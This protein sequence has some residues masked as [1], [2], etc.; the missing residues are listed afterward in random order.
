MEKTGGSERATKDEVGR[1]VE[2]KSAEKG[3]SFFTPPIGEER[4]GP[5]TLFFFPISALTLREDTLEV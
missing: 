5:L 4:T 1:Q 2:A 3:I